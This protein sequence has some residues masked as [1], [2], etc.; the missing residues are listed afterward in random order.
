MPTEFQLIERFL[1][2]F[3]KPRVPVGPGDDCAVLEPFRG[4]ACITT[5]AV[6]EDVHFTRAAFRLEDVGHK[7]L[8]V[9]L[10][11]LA[12]MGATP[13]WFT[14]ALG[15]PSGTSV[16]DVVRLARGMSALA[17]AHD[18]ALVGG[19][20]TSARELSVTITAA[21]EV[22][23]GRALLRSGGRPG[24]L[25]YVS[26][27]LGD[28]AAGL[29]ALRSS[30]GRSPLARRQLRPEPRV[31][32][33][34]CAV[35]FATA[36]IDISDGLLQ[37]LGHLCRASRCSAEVDVSRVPLS[38]ALQRKAR[39]GEQALRWALTGGED[40]ELLFAVAPGRASAFER[41][42]GRAGQRVTRVGALAPRR[43]GRSGSPV[44]LVG[45]GASALRSVPDGFDHFRPVG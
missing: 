42:V 38:G 14:C 40:Y 12:A 9:N 26:G 30:R 6:V 31:A 25:L 41:A 37:D 20:F 35:G 24:D 18:I 7:A 34:R 8:A 1:S 44:R 2:E 10:S 19:N 22:A 5:D 36:A 39:A 13:R 28:A 45:E 17:R 27:T 29:E 32:L 33:G 16:R 15:L 43:S 3:P 11:D 21:G 23:R 4:Q